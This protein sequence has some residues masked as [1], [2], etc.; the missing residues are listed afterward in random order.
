M[1]VHEGLWSH[2][3]WEEGRSLGRAGGY[4]GVMG[5]SLVFRREF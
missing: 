4:Q 2:C 5:R 1:G 3:L